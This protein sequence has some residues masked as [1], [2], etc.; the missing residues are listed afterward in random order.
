M[1]GI[2]TPTGFVSDK[3]G[4]MDAE[5]RCLAEIERQSKMPWFV[6]WDFSNA[7][8]ARL[9]RIRMLLERL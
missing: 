8:E 4:L 3:Q 2:Y 7:L 5:Q 1:E 6:Q 9:G